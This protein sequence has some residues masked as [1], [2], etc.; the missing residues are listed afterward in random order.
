MRVVLLGPYPP[1]HG[2]VQ[3]NLTAIREF[4]LARGV[5]CSVINL[6]RFRA[7]RGEAV[8]HPAGALATLRLLIRL[9]ADVIHLH[10]GGD[11]TPRLLGLSLTCCLMPRAKAVLTFHSG[12]YPSSPA[13]RSARPRTL[14]GFVFRRFD[15][16]IAV[17]PEIAKMFARFG[18]PRE[19]V[20]L[21]APH[22]L[23]AAPNRSEMPERL[24]RFF[25]AHSPVLVSV[26]LLEPEYDLPLQVEAL[27]EIRRRFP[28]A[29]LA[30]IGAGS[31][32]QDLRRRIAAQP[33]SD[34]IL[35][36]GDVPHRGTLAAI[37]GADA[38]LRT[39]L[40]DGDSVSV[41]EALHLGTPVIATDNGMRP[42]GAHLIPASDPAALCRAVEERLGAPRAARAVPEDPR[43][44]NVEAIYELYRELTR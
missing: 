35:L 25:D 37:A 22:P 40:Y 12:G 4:L 14:R 18:V 28:G 31:L 7:G 17:N 2:G 26:G 42:S 10:I 30:L 23:P 9:R 8:Y 29:G 19:R 43:D 38:F 6:H 44:E 5:S 20:R 3:T 21:I 36:C 15:G 13:G 41:R 39:T 1:P 27:G 24:R 32:E 33:W 34:H 11:L 16:I